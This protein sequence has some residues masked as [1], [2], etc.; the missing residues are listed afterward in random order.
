MVLEAAGTKWNFKNPPGLVGWHCIGGSHILLI[1]QE[2]DTNHGWP[3]C[4]TTVPLYVAKRSQH[5]IKNAKDATGARVGYGAT[6]KEMQR[7]PQLED[8]RFS[9]RAEGFF[10]ECGYR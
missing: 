10:I 5:I 2:L 6:F 1:S 3:M 8:H 4:N 7:Y 9:K